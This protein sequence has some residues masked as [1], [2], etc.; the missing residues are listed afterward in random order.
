M[1]E[2]KK[3][4]KKDFEERINRLFSNVEGC[5]KTVE[6]QLGDLTSLKGEFS[7]IV[8]ELNQVKGMLR[9][10]KKLT[11][12]KLEAI[13]DAVVILEEE[14][15]EKRKKVNELSKGKAEEYLTS[16]QY[17]RADFENY[18]RRAEKEKREFADFCI[19]CVIKDLLP[20][21]DALEVAVGHSTKNNNSEGLLKG[22]EMTVKQITELLNREGIEEIQALGELFDPFKHEVVAKE[23]AENHPENTVIEVMRKGYLF[24]GKVIRPAMVKLAIKE[25]IKE[26]EQ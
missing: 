15:E 5:S 9:E 16:L 11:E 14:L 2:S 17:L 4:R 7:G 3:H 20:I 8:K 23:M 18:K 1:T 25:L 26:Q 24:R 6:A 13:S 21:K 10:E 12:E 22:V 19:E